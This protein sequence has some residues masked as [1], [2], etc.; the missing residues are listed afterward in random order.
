M[1][2]EPLFVVSIG[3][4][5]TTLLMSLLTQHPRIVSDTAYPFEFRP[6]AASAMPENKSLTD[7]VFA[8]PLDGDRGKLLAP[9]YEQGLTPAAT[10]RIL[11][12]LA[13]AQGKT[14]LFAAE[15][16]GARLLPVVQTA[17]PTARYVLLLRDP[18]D[19]IVSARA[20]DVKR[21]FR[22][23][24]ER[25]GDSDEDVVLKYKPLID[26][27]ADFLKRDRPIP[28]RY[29]ELMCWRDETLQRVFGGLGLEPCAG[30]EPP[31]LGHHR[32]A[33]SDSASTKR[34]PTEMSSAMQQLFRR[35]M[36]E[37]LVTLGF[38]P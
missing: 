21:G 17:Y 4:S 8:Y 19:V 5:G 12:N 6:F 27:L 23:F 16:V 30:I 14:P 26:A 24:Q 2:I 32:T 25:D 7:A 37:S 9:A 13:A 31:P 10:R 29:D 34:W 38:L 18:R 11:G 22:G 36:E 35:H 3:R 1:S 33:A 20:F 28:I 15:K